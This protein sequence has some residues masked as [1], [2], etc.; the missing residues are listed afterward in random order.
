MHHENARV[1][2]HVHRVN[3]FDILKTFG[4]L[5]IK[6]HLFSREISTMNKNC[7][8]FSSCTRKNIAYLACTW[9]ITTEYFIHTTT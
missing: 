9:D 4:R 7:G 3:I 8:K 1:F 5:I 2:A 6:M